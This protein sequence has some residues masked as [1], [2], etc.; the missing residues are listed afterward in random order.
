MA[1]RRFS[2]PRFAGLQLGSHNR[3]AIRARLRPN[4]AQKLCS[5]GIEAIGR[6][7]ADLT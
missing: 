5:W 6:F 2:V 7:S 4:G 3:L 1:A